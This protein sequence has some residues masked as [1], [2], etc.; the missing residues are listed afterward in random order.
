[1]KRYRWL[2]AVFAVMALVAAGCG[3][4]DGGGG[5]DAGGSDAIPADEALDEI[6]E[7]EGTVSIVAWP[8]Y[9]ERGETEGFEDYDWVTGFEEETGCSVEVQ[10]AGTSDEMVSLMTG[11]DEYDLVTA[12]GDAS[13]RLI[14]GGTVAPV[15]I[16]LIEGYD[17][18][19][20]ELQDAPWHTVDGVHYGVPYQWG[21]DVLMYNTE[22][23]PEPPTSWS[24]VFEEQDLP[25][26]ETNSGRIQAYDGPIYIASAALYLRETQPDLGI[27][28]PYALNQ[29]QYD[30][31]LELLREQHP[32][33]H[34]Y[35]HDYVVQIED[36][37]NEGIAASGSWPVQANL[38][39]AD[40]QPIA[41]TIPE[42]GATGWADTTLLAAN[43]P[44]PNCAYLWMQ[45]SIDPKV[46]GDVAAY[47]GSVPAVEAAC[48]GNE[49]LT[50]EGCQTNGIENFDQIEFWKTPEAN[51]FEGAEGDCVPYS[52]W[53]EDYNAIMSGN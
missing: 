50:D 35:W 22:V 13:L 24:V 32:L 36:F 33:V 20:E 7:G 48:E 42:E 28:D 19:R 29:E 9:I 26:G 31:A 34:R 18:V 47:F 3:D 40:E 43:A 44:H 51:C 2:F 41:S 4:D 23:F 37:T 53:T 30:A 8:G 15:N 38:L 12:S 5:G 45:H 14:R 16:D 21:S 49:L 17:T 39:I 6:G 46:Q 10:T 1:M 52:Q 27:E 11:S 25:D